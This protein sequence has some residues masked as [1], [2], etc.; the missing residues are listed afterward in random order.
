MLLFDSFL[1]P[2]VEKIASFVQKCGSPSFIIDLDFN[3][4]EKKDA[5]KKCLETRIRLKEGLE[6]D[7]EVPAE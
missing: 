2:E 1:Y 6:P 7:A 3:F 4:N 5:S